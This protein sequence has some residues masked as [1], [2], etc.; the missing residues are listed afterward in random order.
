MRHIL[1]YLPPASD[2]RASTYE[3]HN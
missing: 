1:L 2:S 3:E